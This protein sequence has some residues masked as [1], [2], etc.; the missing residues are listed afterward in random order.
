MASNSGDD[1]EWITV[2]GNHIPVKKGQTKE[3][4]VK[5]FIESKKGN[6]K[7]VP[8]DDGISG[9]IKKAYEIYKE[10]NCESTKPAYH[11]PKTVAGVKRGR[12][13]SFEQADSGRTNPNYSRNNYAYSH[14]CQ[15]CVVAHELRLRGYDVKAAPRARSG[16]T[17]E[18]ARHSA[19]AWIDP[20]TGKKCKYTK[21]NVKNANEH[22]NYLNKHI[23][24][25]AR[26]QITFCWEDKKRNIYGHVLTISRNPLGVLR[27]YDPQTSRIYENKNI[28]K[29]F[30][31][32][33]I[34]Y[35]DANLKPKL[36]RVDDK[37][38]NPYF[39]DDVVQ[40]L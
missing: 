4:A 34:I 18:L 25:E 36:L 19:W 27:M 14:N 23:K 13:M 7:N 24:S 16:K 37:K 31:H 2:K 40:K 3:D 5:E 6:T 35:N 39:M 9:F 22:F 12:P 15:S 17:A 30:N 29:Y 1:I 8:A 10:V 32:R 21:I 11:Y 28:E 20:E 38:I 26:Y 33:S